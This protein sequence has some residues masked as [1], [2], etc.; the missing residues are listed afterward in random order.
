MKNRDL[1]LSD[2]A[3][4]WLARLRRG[5][6]SEH[7]LMEFEAWKGQSREH[8]EAWAEICALWDDP[9]IMT[10][11]HAVAPS[12]SR[13]R[14]AT[15]LSLFRRPLI[16]T[17]AAAAFAV[18]LI[19]IVLAGRDVLLQFQADYRTA[20]G[21]QRRLQLQDGSA[22]TLNTKTAI[23]TE[24]LGPTRRIKLLAGEAFFAVSADPHKPFLVESRNVMARAL[25]TSF[26]VKEQGDGLQ[27]AVIE[28]RV[29]VSLRG[30]ESAH[31]ELRAGQQ[32]AIVGDRLSLPTPANP[33]L[34]TAWLRRR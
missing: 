19:F 16:A 23:A 32:V 11:L 31:V 21:E 14:G 27:V 24:F 22:V 17:A 29:D 5:H 33:E 13:P 28:G 3:A 9:A 7:D 10:A 18:V 20:S 25:G 30:N 26:L 4:A 34:L 1:F 2:E 12:P 6:L 8:E 15:R